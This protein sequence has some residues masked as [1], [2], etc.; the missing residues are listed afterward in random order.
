MLDLFIRQIIIISLFNENLDIPSVFGKILCG[1]DFS[2]NLE[3]YGYSLKPATVN[4]NESKPL[5]TSTTSKF[6]TK[7]AKKIKEINQGK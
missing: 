5:P 1:P 6:K 2:L 3:D 7:K 4:L